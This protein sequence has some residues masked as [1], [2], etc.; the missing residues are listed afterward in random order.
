[1]P[2]D[3]KHYIRFYDRVLSRVY[4]LLLKWWFAPFGGESRVR[5]QLLEPVSFSANDHILDMCC[6]TGSA[7]LAIAKEA[8][9][10]AEVVGLDLSLGQIRR[11]RAK[12]SNRNVRF[13]A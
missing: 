6:G 3:R 13:L 2:L 5:K 9:Q 4:D 11:A 8:G 7:T 10:A 1:M 12:T